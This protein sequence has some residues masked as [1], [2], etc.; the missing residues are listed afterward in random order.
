MSIEGMSREQRRMLRKMGAVNEA[1][2]PV[3]TPRST[4]VTRQQ[5][6]RT[7]PAEF[8]REVRGELRKVAWPTKQE[9]KVYSIVVLITVIIF[10]LLVFGLDWTAGKSLLWLF[11]K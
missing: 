2:A 7:S 4:A 3:R 6:T 10:T 1:G 5:D 9:V 8:I 11:D